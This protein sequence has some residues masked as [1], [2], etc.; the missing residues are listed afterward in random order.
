MYPVDLRKTAELARAFSGLDQA[1]AER[2]ADLALRVEPFLDEVTESFYARLLAIEPAA[3]YLEG[4][5][6]TL[7]QTHRAWLGSIFSGSYDTEFAAAMYSVG[8]AHVNVRLPLEFM[9]GAMTLI[10]DSLIPVLAR[11]CEDRDELSDAAQSVNAVLGFSLMIMQESYHA[12]SMA[13][14]LSR[15]LKVT[16]MSRELFSNLAD[17]EK[18]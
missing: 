18:H 1:R 14:E 9:A 3:L 13:N 12:T 5:V 11:V 7:K 8:E 4:R 10:T 2:L 15:F 16:G 6:E 17:T